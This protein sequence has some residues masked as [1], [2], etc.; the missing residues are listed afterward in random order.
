[1]PDTTV[2]NESLAKEY[3]CEGD[4]CGPTAKKRV[5]IRYCSGKEAACTGYTEWR[6]WTEVAQCGAQ[7]SCETDGSTYSKCV[8]CAGGC[9]SNT[10]CRCS[11]GECC[12][13]CNFKSGSTACGEEKK[14]QRCG[15]GEGQCGAEIQ[16]R[17]GR[18]GCTGQSA[19][20]AGDVRWS[21]WTAV[22]ACGEGEV[23]SQP[24]H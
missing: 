12:D 4:V 22:Q 17:A 1:M 19:E 3:M 6:D 2:C 20:C 8:D 14:E 11:S 24:E 10:C 5:E 23:C 21:D 9:K 15:G 7:Q 18:A 13:G 16:E